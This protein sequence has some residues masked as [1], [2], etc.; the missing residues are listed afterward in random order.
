VVQKTRQYFPVYDLKP[1]LHVELEIAA[2]GIAQ[3]EVSATRVVVD[4]TL[5]R[6]ERADMA[7]TKMPISPVIVNGFENGFHQWIQRIFLVV[8]E[9]EKIVFRNFFFKSWIHFAAL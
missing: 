4:A 2:Q 6:M 7:V 3:C 1:W 9:V 5:R 8:V